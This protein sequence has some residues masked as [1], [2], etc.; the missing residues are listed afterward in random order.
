MQTPSPL[1]PAVL[2]PAV[3]ARP[4]GRAAIRHALG[5]VRAAL[6]W[7]LLLWWALLLLLPAL[8][9]TL[10]VW[11][12][13]GASF[14]HSPDAARLAERVDLLAVADLVTTVHERHGGALRG[15]AAVALVLTLLLSP[16]LS[17]M[18]AYAARADGSAPPPRFAALLS[19]GAHEYG[20]MLR[21]LVWAAIPLGAVAML[22][23]LASGAASKAAEAASLQ[24]SADRANGLV[25]LATVLL[26]A[27]AHLT[28]ET[29]R[30]LLA[31][32]DGSGRRRRSAVLAWLGACRLLLRRPLALIG[33]YLAVTLPGLA[34]AALLGLV[35][36]HLDASGTAWLW[37]G[38]ALTQL[39][40]MVLGWMRAARL[41]AFMALVR[42]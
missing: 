38:F 31:Q 22:N 42:G 3:A 34:I 5:R 1:E 25:L 29:G 2:P 19:G 16:L 15:G 39:I 8:L 28:L 18:T 30:A 41:F 12:I 6:Q 9:A 14:D 10:P 4:A 40:V 23:S 26:A 27:L 32:D 13:L 20:R 21:M 33:L 11:Q 24:A 36:A 7:R 17:G 37:A 35:R